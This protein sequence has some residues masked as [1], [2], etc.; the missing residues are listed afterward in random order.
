MQLFFYF[1]CFLQINK[2]KTVLKK[3]SEKKWSLRLRSRCLHSPRKTSCT[4]DWSSHFWSVLF[5][6]SCSPCSCSFME[7]WTPREPCS[8]PPSSGTSCT[9]GSPSFYLSST[10]SSKSSNLQ[11]WTRLLSSPGMRRTSRTTGICDLK[12]KFLLS[13]F[14][15]SKTPVQNLLI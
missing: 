10:S 6:S 13:I 14:W 3:C 7:E 1:P 12:C 15:C 2:V 4:W 11:S 9:S 8:S 5:S